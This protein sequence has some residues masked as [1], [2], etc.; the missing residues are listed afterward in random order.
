MIHN[1]ILIPHNNNNNNSSNMT[2]ILRFEIKM[3]FVFIISLDII[4]YYGVLFKCRSTF[5]YIFLFGVLIVL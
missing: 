1:I 4:N 3:I 5:S 2:H